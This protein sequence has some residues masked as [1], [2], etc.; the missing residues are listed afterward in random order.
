[1]A[2]RHA[3]GTTEN[4][5]QIDGSPEYL[6]M[7]QRLSKSES[8]HPA[9][10]YRSMEEAAKDVPREL[11]RK[12]RKAAGLPASPDVG[13]LSGLLRELR[14]KAESHLSQTV[15]SAVIS[16]TRLTGLY[17]ED[18][19]DAAEYLKL[20]T[21]RG[22]HLHQPR[23]IIAAYAGNGMGLCKNFEDVTQC[24]QEGKELPLR[25][26]LS[27]E[28]VKTA[29]VLNTQGVREAL[30]VADYDTV[31][32]VDFSD[33]FD[34][35][36]RVTASITDILEERFRFL[37]RPSDLT[38]VISGDNADLSISQTVTS[39]VRTFGPTPALFEA[40]PLYIA[41]RGAAELAWRAQASGIQAN[42]TVLPSEI[43]TA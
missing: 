21:L 2:C 9:P 10:P 18:I 15:G 34:T 26:V 13:T 40:E 41:A 19:L 33:G 12:G 27:V 22:Y 42:D 4:I 24:K 25:Q 38:V 36:E 14:Q 7:M 20:E 17:E 32:K 3:D 28:W 5:A 23:E 30:D 31:A 37:Q 11:I 16:Y 29:L 1:M 39:A 35:P 43:M 6:D 8:A